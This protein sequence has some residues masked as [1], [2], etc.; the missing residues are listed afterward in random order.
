MKWIIYFKV[1]KARK[2]QQ[3]KYPSNII[4]NPKLD[5]VLNNNMILAVN[6]SCLGCHY[7]KE[8]AIQRAYRLKKKGMIVKIKNYAGEE[9]YI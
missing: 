3:L 7:D 6:Y 5:C 1:P 4:T 8:E 9:I 2:F